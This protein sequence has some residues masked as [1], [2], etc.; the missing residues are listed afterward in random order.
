M[1]IQ[2]ILQRNDYLQKN[3]KEIEDPKTEEKS[4]TRLSKELNMVISE[5]TVLILFIKYT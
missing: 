5:K 3:K 1:R 2:F 4:I